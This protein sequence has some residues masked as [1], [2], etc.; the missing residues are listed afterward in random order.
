MAQTTTY[1]LTGL[2]ENLT[3]YLTI[4]EPETTPKLSLLP[5][6]EAPKQAFQEWQ[7]DNLAAPSF[8]GIVDG[9]DVT[10]FQNKAKNRARAGNYIQIFRQPWAV[11]T[12]TEL[13]DVAGISNEVAN[14]KDKSVRELKRSIESAIGSDNDRQADD[15]SVP[16][17][18]RGMGSW[19]SSSGPTD[20]PAAYRPASAQVINTASGSFT[21]DVLNGV[22]QSQAESVGAKRNLTL[23]A[24]PGLKRTISK[25]QRNV[26]GTQAGFFVTEPAADRE[27]I[28][29]VDLYDGDMGV[30]NIILD[31]LSGITSD[32]TDGAFFT[33]TSRYRGYCIN[34]EEWGLGYLKGI[35]AVELPNLGGGRRG[36]VESIATLV[37]KNPKGSAKFYGTS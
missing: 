20:I 24:G 11:S 6:T 2:R 34:P 27:L 31:F 37:C 16:F 7:M 12:I 32:S 25:F 14:A 21:E 26:G 15:G 33:G 4:L 36:Y 23:F 10:N 18:M 17:K 3:N 35:E 8:G 29:A 13:S 19:I 28:L 1:N 30:V 22:L 5:K 9:L